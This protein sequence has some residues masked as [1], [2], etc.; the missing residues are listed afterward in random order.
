VHCS[1]QFCAQVFGEGVAPVSG[2][3]YLIILVYTLAW[4]ISLDWLL[5][6]TGILL[7]QGQGARRV[8]SAYG[9]VTRVLSM[10]KQAQSFIF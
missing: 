3:N 8:A 10:V 2:W 6:A 5:I 7:Y 9:R 4:C 1:W